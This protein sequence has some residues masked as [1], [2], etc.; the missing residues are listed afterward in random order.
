MFGKRTSLLNDKKI[1]AIHL[2][3]Y[4]KKLL[5]KHTYF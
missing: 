2:Q 1:V 4:L 5:S 3:H